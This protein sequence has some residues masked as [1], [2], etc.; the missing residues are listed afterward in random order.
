VGGNLGADSS[1]ANFSISTWTITANA[2]VGGSVAP[3]SAVPVVEGASQHFS[4]APAPGSHVASLTVDGG[5]VTPDTAYTFTNVAA[6]HTL[7]ATFSATSSTTVVISEFRTN[8]PNGGSDEFIELYN[9]SD[10]PASVGGWLVTGSNSSGETATLATITAG[11]V[12]GAHCHYLLANESTSGGPYSGSIASDQ[13]YSTE[14][15]DDGGVALLDGTT[16]VDAVGMSAGSAYKEGTVLAPLTGNSNQS[17]ER[18]PGGASGSGQ[19]TDDN[20]SDFAVRTPSD[21]Q[22]LNSTAPTVAVTAPV[23]GE[24]WK[25]GST[26]AI[27]WTATDNVSVTAIDLA[28]STN[29]GASFPNVITTGLANSGSYAW[30]VPNAAGSAARVRVTA[31]DA[32]GNLGADSSAANFTISTWTITAS[33]GA[34][35]SVV[36]G[37]AVPVVEGASQHFS[38]APAPGNY[39]ASVSV[40][41]A[42]VAPDT[43]YTFASVTAN[44]SIAAAFAASGPKT[45]VISEFR[46][47]G[48]NGGSDE[49]IELY[50]LSDSPV[51]IGGWLVRGSNSSAGTTTRAT[52]TAGV[53]LGAH[54]HYLLTNRATGGGPYSGSVIGDQT[55][56][57]GITDTGGIG[58]LDG[59]T[60]VDQVGMSTGSVYKEGTVLAALTGNLNQS[61]E[62]KPGGASGS[63]QDTD[64]NASD[65]QVRNPSDPQN[66]AS[67]A[68]DVAP[69]VVQVTSPVGG[70]A[71]EEGSAQTIEWSASDNVG[72]DSVN[73]DCSFTGVG[74]PWQPVAHGLPNSGSLPWTVPGPPTDSALV[75]VTAYDHARNAGS[76][77]SDGPF[78]IVRST[79]GVGT[80][81]P[82]VLAL[83]RPQPNPGRGT[84]LLRFSLPQAGN[85]GL[86]ILDLSGRRVWRV[87]AE[88]EAGPHS[89]RWDGR[90]EQG[91]SA[92]AGVYFVRLV[93]PWGNR[94]ERLVWLR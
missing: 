17:Y 80:R 18:K 41:G 67:G 34:G 26:H 24:N 81:G 44:H 15:A 93:T 52:I 87:E 69:P 75:R 47:N 32:V 1:A 94:T 61:Y 65:F 36:P 86:E 79:T 45:V 37:G 3:S 5:P 10:S 23:G 70:E 28:Y 85:A 2:G 35:G 77:M 57:T 76:A 89:C 38:I 16:I 39:V 33:A 48:P 90:G 8:G 62:R 19:D 66:L 14:I 42:P 13:T 30:T 31:H 78:H 74:G 40:D 54:C 49:F 25:A 64:D 53:V 20:A 83:A 4:I 51:S 22:N 46:T 58:L 92:G 59:T 82:A 84:T 68:L 55:Y 73:V 71:W 12:L 43:A 9:L 72:V 11:V 29:G 21:P 50:N 63:G 91:G 27:T 6:N 56:S 7:E 60:V 88:L